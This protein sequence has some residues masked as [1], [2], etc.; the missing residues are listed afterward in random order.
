MPFNNTRLNTPKHNDF[1]RRRGEWV[2]WQPAV[3][4]PCGS[5]PDR[6][7]INCP[8]CGGLGVFH[9]EGKEIRGLVTGVEQEKKLLEAGIA[10]PG[11]MIF[12]QEVGGVKLSDYDMIKLT[13][14]DGIPFEGQIVSRATGSATDTLYYEAKDI[15][16]CLAINETTGEITD[17]ILDTDFSVSG[18]TITW[19]TG[20]KKPANGAKYSIKYSAVF[21]WL[22]FLPPFPRVER[23]T[24]IGQ[25]V[26]L[27]KRHI[28]FANR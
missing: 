27:R 8:V 18:K 24:D 16:Q 22:V 12:S 4:C 6:A 11:D 2:I 20:G 3:K 25:K 15:S 9:R 28:V 14:K 23:G 10:I 17:Y 21:E 7:N 13:W 5:S 1:I 19:L 26:L